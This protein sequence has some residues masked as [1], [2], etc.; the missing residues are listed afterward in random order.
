MDYFRENNTPDTSQFIQWEA[1]KCVLRGKFLA[2]ASAVKWEK[3]TYLREIFSK[4]KRLEATHKCTLAQQTYQELVET[5]TL[6]QDE[7]GCKL[8]RKHAL[9]QKL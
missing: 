5:L 1:H 4:L 9:S 2:L 6:L 3:Q 8:K 7:L